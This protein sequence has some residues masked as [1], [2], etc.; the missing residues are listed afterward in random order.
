MYRLDGDSDCNPADT[1][2]LH[3]QGLAAIAN[4]CG[5]ELSEARSDPASP[6]ASF[7]FSSTPYT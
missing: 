1:S 4:V 6:A 5:H 2:G 7:W 3:S